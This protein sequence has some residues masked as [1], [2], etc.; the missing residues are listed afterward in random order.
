MPELP[1]RLTDATTF[2]VALLQAVFAREGDPGRLGR[3]GIGRIGKHEES[4][5]VAHVPHR[6]LAA[7]L[8]DQAHRYRRAGRV[9]L[10]RVQQRVQPGKGALHG[11]RERA[12]AR[13]PTALLDEEFEE[14]H[15]HERSRFRPAVTIRNRRT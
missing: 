9:P 3:R 1:P 8:V 7:R 2:V 10:V 4:S 14:V 6:Q 15:H 5:R 12:A 11:L 13:V